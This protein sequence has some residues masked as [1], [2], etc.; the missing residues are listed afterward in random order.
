[1]KMQI[2]LHIARSEARWPSRKEI[3]DTAGHF[4]AKNTGNRNL[5]GSTVGFL[6]SRPPH[7]ASFELIG[8]GLW[9]YRTR[10]G[11]ARPGISLP[12]HCCEHARKQSSRRRREYLALDHGR[13]ARTA[14]QLTVQYIIS[15]TGDPDGS[16]PSAYYATSDPSSFR[17]F[18]S[19]CDVLVA[20]LPSTPQ[21][22]Y[23]LT[24][25]HLGEYLPGVAPVKSRPFAD[26]IAAL[27]NG[28]I[29]INV[30]RGD[31]VRSGTSRNHYP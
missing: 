27:P 30:G 19:R 20:S 29:F 25:E 18:L 4:D 31:L 26:I 13:S 23:M 9:T 16:I 17:D 7:L 24:A 28:A 2:Q 1:M 12:C 5:R 11:A 8:T 15:G 6:V 22:R 3:N 21:T 14:L 10:D